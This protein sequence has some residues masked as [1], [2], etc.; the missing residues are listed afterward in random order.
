MSLPPFRIQACKVIGC[1][2]TGAYCL[3]NPVGSKYASAVCGGGKKLALMF[4][5][6]KVLESI[7]THV[8]CHSNYKIL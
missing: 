5:W 1:F 4:K 3:T 2:I 7:V 8:I 6:S